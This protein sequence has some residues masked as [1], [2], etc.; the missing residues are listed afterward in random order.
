MKHLVF[1][2]ISFLLILGNPSKAF[3]QADI[4]M[5]THWNNRA[6]YNPA[7][8]ARTEYLYLFSNVRHQWTGVNGAPTVFN[9]QASEYIHN[10]HSAFGISIINDKIGLTS[11]LN[12][13]LTYAF[14][15]SP[16]IDQDSWALSFGLSAGIFVRTVNGSEYD[17]TDAVDPAI[18]YSDMTS[19]SP[20]ANIGIEWQNNH[21]IL[22]LASTH[23]F[24]LGNSYS[25]FQNTNHRYLYAKYK[26]TEAENFNFS[27]GMEGVNRSKLTYAECNASIRFKHPTGLENGPRELFDVGLSFRT[28]KQLSLLLGVNITNNFRIGY[29]YDHSFNPD[30]NFSGSHEMMLE[31]RIPTKASSICESCLG[32]RDWYY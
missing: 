26:Y 13:L 4:S 19:Y 20:D 30:I 9:F 27:F 2:T 11:V 23:I 1:I 25:L 32:Q 24:A 7:S 6:N 31:Y 8:I 15:I 29:S 12:P 18:T 14:R 5:T 16:N 28:T 10:L 17:P 22:G 3:G 21:F